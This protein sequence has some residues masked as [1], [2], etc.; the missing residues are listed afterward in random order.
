MRHRAELTEAISGILRQR[1]A[2]HWLAEFDRA[3]VPA[4]PVHSVGEALSHPQTL[5]RDM[6]VRQQHPDAGEI[7][8]IGMPVKFSATPA[9][10]HRAAPRPGEDTRAILAEHGYSDADIQSLLDMGVARDVQTA[11]ASA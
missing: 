2:E 1:P 6:V 11:D 3:G 10:Y 5:A 9:R 4:G 8:T 7:S